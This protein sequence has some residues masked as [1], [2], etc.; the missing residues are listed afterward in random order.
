MTHEAFDAQAHTV[1]TNLLISDTKISELQAQTS[2]NPALQELIRI[3]QIRW[4]DQ[5]RQCPKSALPYWNYRDELAVVDGLVLKGERIVVPAA[6]DR[7]MLK[8]IHVGHI[9]IVKCKN[10]AKEVMFWPNMHSQIEE[11]VS[12][13]ATC[14]QFRISNPKDPMISHEVPESPWQIVAA[15]LFQIDDEHYL[16]V[17]D[18]HSRYFELEKM[19]STTCSAVVRRMKAAIP[20]RVVSDNGP[21]FAAE[22]F[23]RFAHDWEFRHVTMSPHYLH[24]NGL[25]GRFRSNSKALTQESQDR[26]PGSLPQS[27]SI[28]EQSNRWISLSIPTLNE[29]KTSCNPTNDQ[30]SA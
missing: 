5:R 17:V 28:Q 16:I 8:R 4:Q 7:E 27:F 15:D 2:D 1:M 25:V 6:A 3:I 12:N 20:E 30:E 14:L 29:Q 26:V 11:M 23:S 13:C 18:Y 21:Q 9:G 24:E 19:S 22:E 10:R